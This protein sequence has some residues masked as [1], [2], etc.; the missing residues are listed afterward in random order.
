MAT[1][2]ERTKFVEQSGGALALKSPDNTAQNNCGRVAQQKMDVVGFSSKFNNGT[3]GA[4]SDISKSPIK[5][6]Q[7]LA[8]KRAALNFVQKTTCTIK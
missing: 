7:T 8:G 4:K 5:K 3:V 1:P 6:I 2:R